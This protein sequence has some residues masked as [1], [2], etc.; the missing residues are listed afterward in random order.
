MGL[1]D[2]GSHTNWHV[3]CVWR[4]GQGADRP[5]LLALHVTASRRNW[6]PRPD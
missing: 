2:D 3:P 5:R 4:N 6:R 1:V